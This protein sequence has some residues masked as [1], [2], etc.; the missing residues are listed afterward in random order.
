MKEVN[1]E[2]LKEAAHR[3]LFDMSDEEYQTLLK[4]FDTIVKQMHFIADDK[5]VEEY[6]PLVYPFPCNVDTLREDEPNKPS[7]REELLKNAKNK[8]AGQI[9]VSKVNV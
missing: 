9:K 5:S 1:L 4:E 2:S 3:L 7:N 6:T 8:L